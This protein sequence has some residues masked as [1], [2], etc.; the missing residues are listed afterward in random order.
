[1]TSSGGPFAYAEAIDAAA[2]MAA[3]ELDGVL[4]GLDYGRP[5]ECKAAL[6]AAVPAIVEKYGDVAALAAAEHY[7]AERAA[8]VGG[9]FDPLLAGPVERGAI[10]ARVRFALKHV[11]VEGG[12]DART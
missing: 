7:A 8:T 1:M 9:G 5:A 10:E 6:L 12:A 4:D 2:R 11:F 3:R